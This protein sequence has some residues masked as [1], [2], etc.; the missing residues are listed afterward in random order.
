[1]IEG[2]G[3]SGSAGRY[4]LKGGVHMQRV[5]AETGKTVKLGLGALALAIVAVP[6]AGALA[7]DDQPA[8]AALSADQVTKGRQLFSD[9]GCNA[10][11]TL[12][13][14]N[15][16]GTV[17]PSFDGDT[18]LDK[19]LAVATITNGRG[20]MPNFGWMDAKD[21]DLVAAYIVQ[22]KK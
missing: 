15:A 20:P 11:H 19:A 13:D 21:I 10:C 17:G 6:L 22:V 1:M 5:A 16:A 9:N 2:C 14:A 18:G 4:R 8:P 12:G 7:A 3:D